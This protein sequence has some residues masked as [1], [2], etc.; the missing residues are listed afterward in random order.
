[1]NPEIYREMAALQEQHWWFAARRLILAAV[2]RRLPLPEQAEILE[3]GCGTGGNLGM[4]SA[5]GRVSAMEY[6]DYARA[7]AT[8][9]SG[10][11]VAAGALPESVPF[12]DGQFDL[13]CLLDVLEHI[14]D[15]GAALARVKRLLKP[16]G[17][18]LVTVPAYSWLWSSHDAAHHHR[19]RY[20]AGL[21]RRKAD[22]AG[23]T[24]RRLGYCNTLLFPLIAGV[25]LLRKLTGGGDDSDAAMPSP[26]LNRLLTQI[27][28]AE[29]HL[30]PHGFLPFGTSA[31][32][33]FSNAPQGTR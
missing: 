14:E 19:R 20:S 13:I 2:I 26:W 25:R 11:A 27:F 5:F 23:L 33:L 22:E 12:A 18:L 28:A 3:I 24:V 29:R 32:A 16:G 8:D 10:V 1:M 31:L 15:D 9:V 30:L 17:Y 6:D 7:V 21:L 4:L